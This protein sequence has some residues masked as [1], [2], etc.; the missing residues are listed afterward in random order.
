MISDNQS[1]KGSRRWLAPSARDSKQTFW[2]AQA[3]HPAWVKSKLTAKPTKL[4]VLFPWIMNLRTD[5]L[6]SQCCC[7]YVMYVCPHPLALEG[8][9]QVYYFNPPIPDGL[10]PQ[11]RIFWGFNWTNAIVSSRCGNGEGRFIVFLC[12]CR[13]C[14]SMFRHIKFYVKSVKQR[15]EACLTPL[16]AARRGIRK[17]SSK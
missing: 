1:F 7:M 8:C 3:S 14:F 4:V 11:V 6:R 16:I 13:M 9:K 5:Q 15:L 10:Y 2:T 12:L 17:V